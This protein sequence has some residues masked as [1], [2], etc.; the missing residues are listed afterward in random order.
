MNLSR[1]PQQLVPVNHNDN[2]CGSEFK[3]VVL[4]GFRRHPGVVTIRRDDHLAPAPAFAGHPDAD[5][6]R[7]QAR[8]EQFCDLGR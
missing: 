2:D 7:R 6:A 1:V 8:R 4:A 5:G 3:S